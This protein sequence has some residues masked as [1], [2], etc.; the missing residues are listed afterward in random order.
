MEIT[1]VSLFTTHCNE[2]EALKT[3][4]DWW[5]EFLLKQFLNVLSEIKKKI[6]KNNE[7]NVRFK[8]YGSV[9]GGLFNKAFKNIL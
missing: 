6:Y 2:T 9:I 4:F 3:W 5:E 7:A 8:K 1:E